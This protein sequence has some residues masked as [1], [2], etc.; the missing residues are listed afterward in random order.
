MY[1]YLAGYNGQRQEVVRRIN[2]I[3]HLLVVPEISADFLADSPGV[4]ACAK[5]K[6]S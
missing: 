6:Q 2:V 5:L 4:L 1:Q 3:Q